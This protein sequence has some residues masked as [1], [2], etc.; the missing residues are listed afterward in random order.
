MDFFK[1]KTVRLVAWIC[2]VAS[3]IV[4]ALGGTGA[5]DIAKTVTLVF[6]AIG[7]ISAVVVFIYEQI[8]K[9]ELDKASQKKKE[10]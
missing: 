5:A 1:D 6:A 8:I 9:K 4:L 10:E 7:A 2:L 3:I